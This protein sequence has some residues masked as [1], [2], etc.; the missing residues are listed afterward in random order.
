MFKLSL[1]CQWES[2]PLDWF[3]CPLDI[4]QYSHASL[5]STAIFLE[6][7]FPCV[8]WELTSF[9]VIKNNLYWSIVYIHSY[10]QYIHIY[11][12]T[13]APAFSNFDCMSSCHNHNLSSPQTFL[14]LVAISLLLFSVPGTNWSTFSQCKFVIYRILGK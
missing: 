3:F 8:T 12:Y 5:L 2:L 6:S 9:L 4:P 13:Y 11:M 7:I 10:I 1:T 14:C